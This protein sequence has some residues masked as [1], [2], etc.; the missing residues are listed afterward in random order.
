MKNLF[1]STTKAQ[2]SV[3][4]VAVILFVSSCVG[5]QSV[6]KRSGIVKDFST[7]KTSTK[8]CTNTYLIYSKPY[9]TCTS[10]CDEGFHVAT[11]EE[12]SAVKKELVEADGFAIDG[13]PATD[14]LTRVN[15]SLNICVADVIKEIRPT[16]A[17]DIK[18]DFC[19][20]INGKPDIIANCE[21][22]CANKAATTDA[23]LYVNTT[24]GPDVALNSKIGNL[25]NWCSV[26]LAEEDQSP[27]CSLVAYDGTNTINLPVNISAGSNSFNVVVNTLAKN[28]TWI[29]KLQET[30][31]GSKAQ[32]KEFQIRRI[33]QPTSNTGNIGALKI[34]P[35]NQYTCMT[36]GGSV[37]NLGNIIRT[38]F[39]RLFYYFASNETPAPIPPPGGTAQST[40]VCHDEQKHPGKDSALY[41]RLE[42]IPGHI[43]LWDRSDTRF[44]IKAENAGK[45]TIDKI[46]QDR[47]AS[48]YSITSSGTG[49][50]LFSEVT[51]PNRPSTSTTPASNILL[52]FMMIPFVDGDTGK[53]YC[54]T[55]V[56]Y[57]GNSPL[58]NI[59]GEYLPDTEGLF[60]AEK[61]GETIQQGSTYSTVYGAILVKESVLLNYGFY[62]ENG[63]KIRAN[64]ASMNT[65]TI[66][67]YYPTSTTQDA[68]TQGNRRLFTVRTFDTLNGT[69]VTSNTTTERTSDKRI[70][71]IP[72]S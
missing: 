54:P 42:F 69:Q 26:Q 16:N 53:A 19:S 71:C 20:C 72:K 14:I 58:L 34:T 7:S 22:T 55:S 30:R 60:I 57:N 1:T 44:V 61:E 40:V 2:S 35:I 33:E 56:Q 68:L 36:Y 43:S 21:A 45:K 51:F 17:I 65:K 18:T 6:A 48:E 50:N 12:L 39:A 49:I 52:G 31:A 46:I 3:L 29:L 15:N 27:Q 59:L 5:D 10:T 24:P 41:D 47:L 8:G 62:I 11:L 32:T 64:A 28:R 4:I 67:F 63:L 13:V 25:Y 23:I 70:G 66:Y 38:S 9:D 37:D